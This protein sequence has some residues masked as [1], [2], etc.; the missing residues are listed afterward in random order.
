MQIL[1][2]DD[3]ELMRNGLRTVLEKQRGWKVCGE[4]VNGRQAVEMAR[5]L[6]PD[7]IVLDVTMPELNGLEATRQICKAMP[8]AEVLILTMHDSEQLVSEVLAAGAHGYILKADRVHDKSRERNESGPFFDAIC[9]A[10]RQDCSVNHTFLAKRTALLQQMAA[11]DS[12]EL[13]SLKAEYRAGPSGSKSGPYFKHQVWKDGANQSQ[14]V[15]PEDAP[16]L[17]A[18][19]DNR[20][21]F[22]SL[23]QAFIDL[24]VEHARA[25]RLP[26]SLKKKLVRGS[27]PK[28]RRSRS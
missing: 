23:A 14:R 27:L 8:N 12:M 28:Q 3:H 6:R 22:E 4:A 26:D 17:R 13:G 16:A 10:T 1:I 5:K 2:A 21:R 15:T 9:L 7:V 19:I 24:S 20:L 25:H 18:A 11:L